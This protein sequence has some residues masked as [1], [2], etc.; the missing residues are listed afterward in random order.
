MLEYWLI[1]SEYGLK[2]PVFVG[3]YSPNVLMQV[4][5]NTWH[6]TQWTPFLKNTSLLELRGLTQSY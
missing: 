6:K 3:F 4:L 2:S 5:Q 1:K